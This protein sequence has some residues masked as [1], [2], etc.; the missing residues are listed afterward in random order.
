MNYLTGLW[1]YTPSVSSGKCSSR[2]CEEGDAEESEALLRPVFKKLPPFDLSRLCNDSLNVFKG[3][4]TILMTWAHTQLTLLPPVEQYYYS[5]PHFIGN[6][7]SSICFLGFML[8]YGFSC[9]NA[10]LSDW[11]ERSSA[12][13]F[14]RMA[15]S[16]AIPVGGAWCCAFA[17]GWMCFKLPLDFQTFLNILDFRLT[18]GN[19]PDFLLCFSGCIVVM[20]VLRN[21][22]NIGLRKENPVRRC[23][24]IAVLLLLPLA[25]TRLIV[26]D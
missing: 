3:I 17:W 22:V 13:R 4:L 2:A 8:A 21:L 26:T 19:G 15:R 25:L 20:Y 24:C 11:K 5:L 14:Q 6:A 18:L 12:E 9:D 1:G 16:A 7:A 23:V 10:Y